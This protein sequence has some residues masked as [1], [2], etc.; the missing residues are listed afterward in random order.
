MG[1]GAELQA[2]LHREIPVSEAMGVVVMEPGPERVVLE[3]PLAP[4]TNHRSTAFG[5]SVST[6]ATLAGWA[7]IHRRL[8]EAGNPA[9]V[10]IQ[11][12][13][14]EYLLPVHTGFRATCHGVDEAEW[15]RLVRTL[16]RSGMGRARVH[17]EVEAEGEVVVRFEGAYVA[18][19][20]SG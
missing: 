10:V 13:A 12:G 17:V 18:L 6:L 3:A 1:Q 7:L 20:P 16:E 4:N 9:Q 15:R 11:S 19:R 2:Y 5:G 14:T 8:R